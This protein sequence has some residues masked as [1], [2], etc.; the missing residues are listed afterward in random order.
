MPKKECQIQMSCVATASSTT[1]QPPFA[2]LYIPCQANGQFFHAQCM[3]SMLPSISGNPLASFCARIRA[4]SSAL[5]DL[6]YFG[7]NTATTALQNLYKYSMAVDS[8]MRR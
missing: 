2:P 6:K 3:Q 7:P 1:L 8:A 5:G 4:V